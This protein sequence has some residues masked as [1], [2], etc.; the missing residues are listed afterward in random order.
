M[1]KETTIILRRATK[2]DDR[3]IHDLIRLVRINPMDLNWEHFL[4][5][6]DSEGIFLGCGQ[7]KVHHGGV[8]ELASIA[9]VPEARHQGIANQIIRRLIDSTSQNLFLTCRARLETFYQPF[10]FE[11]ITDPIRLP[12]YFKRIAQLSRNLVR[13][14]MISEP[15]LVMYREK[16]NP[17]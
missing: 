17:R 11:K 16:N 10:G 8:H 12:N 3:D 14:R 1:E 4:V 9:V 7:V 5:A 2:A 15:I 6:E 13:M